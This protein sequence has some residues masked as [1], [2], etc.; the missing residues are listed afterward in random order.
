MNK[1][2]T[3]SMLVNSADK[4]RDRFE[5]AVY[6]VVALCTVVIAF[7]GVT[8][9]NSLRDQ[10]TATVSHKAAPATAVVAHASVA[11]PNRG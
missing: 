6:A 1:Q 2:S 7:Q 9:S 5:A 4:G 10:A 8:Q 3:Y 11:E